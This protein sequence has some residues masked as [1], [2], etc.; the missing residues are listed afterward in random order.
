MTLERR[1]QIAAAGAMRP[2]TASGTRSN[3]EAL[4]AC[5]VSG[6]SCGPRGTENENAAAAR[7]RVAREN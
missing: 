3:V 4:V 6:R 2:N 5:A 7:V 1:V